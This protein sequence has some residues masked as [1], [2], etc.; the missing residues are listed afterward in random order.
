MN[1]GEIVE[2]VIR[3]NNLSISELSRRLHVSRRSIY[4][5]FTQP[6]LSFDIICKIGDTLGYD[7]S[8]DFPDLF[9]GR[10]S[11]MIKYI[12]TDRNLEEAQNSAS[13]WRSK[14]I[15]LLEKHNEILSYNPM[16]SQYV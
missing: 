10:E 3:R 15:N 4:N 7:F 14:Y 8:S 11:R 1:N 13:Y 5:W 12:T 16:A 9:N 6:N 2:L